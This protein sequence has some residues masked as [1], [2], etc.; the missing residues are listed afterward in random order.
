LGKNPAVRPKRAGSRK[1][2]ETLRKTGEAFMAPELARLIVE[3]IG[4]KPSEHAIAML[5]RR[6]IAGFV[7]RKPGRDL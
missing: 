1:G 6:A 5:G 3:R 4:K 2:L 7:G